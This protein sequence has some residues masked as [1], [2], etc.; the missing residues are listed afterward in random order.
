[1][2]LRQGH[3]GRAP[4]ALGSAGDGTP[5]LNVGSGLRCH[6]RDKRCIDGDLRAVPQW[7]AICD[8]FDAPV[9]NDG[10]IDIHVGH[11]HVAGNRGTSLPAN[12]SDGALK[13]ERTCCEDASGGAS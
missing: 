4:F 8:N 1:M 7:E 3:S 6:R 10:H 5:R 2:H 12:A 11:T 9:I 13:R